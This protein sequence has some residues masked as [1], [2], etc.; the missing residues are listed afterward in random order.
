[1]ISSKFTNSNSGFSQ[2]HIFYKIESNLNFPRLQ[3]GKMEIQTNSKGLQRTQS[4]PLREYIMQE[5][6]HFVLQRNHKNSIIMKRKE[7]FFC[8]GWKITRHVMSRKTPVWGSTSEWVL[9]LKATLV[10][11]SFW[12]LLQS[13][14][15][16]ESWWK[17]KAL[18]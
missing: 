8:D 13:I 18:L 17:K 1:M 7:A 15:A 6:T 5:G 2:I 12:K 16:W 4:N 11:V 3:H 10:L 14:W 9:L